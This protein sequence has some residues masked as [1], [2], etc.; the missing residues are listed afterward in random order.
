MRRLSALLSTI[1]VTAV[2]AA[3]TSGG[4][5]GWTYAPAPSAT[6]AGSGAAGS[7]GASGSPAA[8]GP[9]SVAPSAGGSPAA[10]GGTGG[11]GGAITITAPVGAATAGFQPTT[12][13]AAAN[14]QFTLTFDNQDNQAP[15]NLILQNA[16]GSNVAVQGDTAF[17]TGPG[18]RDYTVPPLAA[19][20]YKYICQ[21]HP[22]SMMG[23]LTVK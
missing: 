12:A 6:P 7:P 16:D 14:T 4:A 2:V 5:P 21:V 20:S 19:G 23:E 11:T 3:C 9:A 18:K 22:T 1:A 13:E 8:S 17:F 10:S 15:H